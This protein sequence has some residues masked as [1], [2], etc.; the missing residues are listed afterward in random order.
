MGEKCVSGLQGKEL[1]HIRAPTGKGLALPPLKQVDWGKPNVFSI[2]VLFLHLRNH[3]LGLPEWLHLTKLAGQG[4]GKS[5]SG[6]DEW[7]RRSSSCQPYGKAREQHPSSQLPGRLCVCSREEC[8][9]ISLGLS[10]PECVIHTHH[11][12]LQEPWGSGSQKEREN[13]FSSLSS[14]LTIPQPQA[15]RSRLSLPSGFVPAGWV[16]WM[17]SVVSVFIHM[18]H[19]HCTQGADTV[20]NS[21]FVPIQALSTG[22]RAG[23]DRS[24][25]QRTIKILARAEAHSLETSF[26]IIRSSSGWETTT[27]WRESEDSAWISWRPRGPGQWCQLSP[28]PQQPCLT[29]VQE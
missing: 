22:G 10:L 8:Q 7:V 14:N 5:E 27:G 25:Q 18:W 15:P 6:P 11:S 26:G 4:T 3:C 2:W 23:L 16:F 13:K 28:G 20:P 24:S 19:G 17:E 29:L 1:H 12:Q 21:S 9:V